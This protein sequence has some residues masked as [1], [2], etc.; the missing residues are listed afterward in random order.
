[1][2]IGLKFL[3]FYFVL[4]LYQFNFLVTLCYNLSIKK[5]ILQLERSPKNSLSFPPPHYSITYILYSIPASIQCFLST[6]CNYIFRCLCLCC[7]HFLRCLHVFTKVLFTHKSQSVTSFCE[8][9]KRFPLPT[10]WTRQA[11]LP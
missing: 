4:F 7:S 8:A 1:M 3:D 6:T 9:L 10:L 5:C 11:W 2:D